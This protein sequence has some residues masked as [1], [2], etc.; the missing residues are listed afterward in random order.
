MREL[1]KRPVLIQCARTLL[2]GSV[3]ALTGCQGLK[4]TS[5]APFDA[6]LEPAPGGGARYLVLVNTSDKDLHNYSFS[7]YAWDERGANPIAAGTPF[8]SGQGSGRLWKSGEA[9]RFNERG[10]GIEAPLDHAITKVQL[11]GHCDEGAFRQVWTGTESGELRR[12]GVRPELAR[13]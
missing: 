4:P 10:K 5:F 7:V 8:G 9:G 6:R 12:V 1:T 2:L 3:L 13:Q 11:V